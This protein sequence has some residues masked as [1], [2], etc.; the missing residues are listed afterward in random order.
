MSGP[1][2]MVRERNVNGSFLSA[3]RGV[4]AIVVCFA[5]TWQ[6]IV[7]P[8]FGNY[9]WEHAI[10]GLSA[11][12]AVDM[13]YVLSGWVIYHSISSNIG[14]FGR[15]NPFDWYENR[16]FRI[17]PPL[18]VSVAIASVIFIVVRGFHMDRV[19][20]PYRIEPFIYSYRPHHV[21][22]SIL[23]FGFF[24]NLTGG[25]NGPLWSLEIEMQ[26]YFLACV[27]VCAFQRSKLALVILLVAI[28][29]RTSLD[30]NFLLGYGSFLFGFAA[31]WL[32]ERNP[33]RN[34]YD[35]LIA[36]VSVLLMGV[37]VFWMFFAYAVDVTYLDRL[38]EWRSVFTQ[39]VLSFGFAAYLYKGV[40]DHPFPFEETGKF[41]YT[42]YIIHFPILIFISYIYYRVFD[43]LDNIPFMC[44]LFAIS[45]GLCI[46]VA[47][48]I[49]MWV[50]NPKEQKLW[51]NMHVRK[52][53]ERLV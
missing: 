35:R 27:C 7:S 38:A 1:V 25:V 3:C 52:W 46:L 5:H 33:G 48:R 16:S 29:Y 41:S 8:Q 39:L 53:R 23:T 49:S 37:A 31:S 21:A 30:A 28:V 45:A 13:F 17:L 11:R 26:L 4:L 32:Y 15:F 44:V 34:R 47:W 2:L 24:G 36:V 9:G 6:K 20:S 14:R 18:L 12:I 42:L 43:I 22:G 19:P 50:E 40:A 51:F 10:F